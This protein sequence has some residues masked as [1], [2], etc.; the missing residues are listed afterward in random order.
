[1][2]EVA[3][4]ILAAL[5]M[6]IAAP[7]AWAGGDPPPLERTETHLAHAERAL[8]RLT[9]DFSSL[10]VL[11]EPASTIIVGNT[12]IAGAT[13]SDDR[14]LILTGLTAGSTNLI[15]LDEEGEEITNLILEVVSGGPHMVTVHQGLSRQTFTCARRCEP[16]LSVGDNADFFSTTASQVSTRRGFTDSGA[17]E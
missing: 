7:P 15:V 4:R 17:A 3:S 11:D 10:L 13:L 16:V 14:T 5:A 8:V 9:I 12:A 2:R 6:T 1:M